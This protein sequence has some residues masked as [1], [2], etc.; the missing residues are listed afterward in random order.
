MIIN[1]FLRPRPQLN[2][3]NKLSLLIN[4]KIFLLPQNRSIVT[5]VK[6]FKKM[7]DPK[8]VKSLQTIPIADTVYGWELSPSICH[9]F[10]SR[11][12]AYYSLSVSP[13]RFTDDFQF[14]IYT[15]TH[16]QLPT[17]DEFVIHLRN[18]YDIERFHK[19][20]FCQ[21]PS[22]IIFEQLPL[23]AASIKNETLLGL[24]DL[25]EYFDLSSHDVCVKKH[26][27]SKRNILSKLTDHSAYELLAGNEHTEFYTVSSSLYYEAKI[28]T[29]NNKVNIMSDYYSNFNH[30]KL[31]IATASE[32]SA[33]FGCKLNSVA[34]YIGVKWS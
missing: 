33:L 13:I 30:G 7:T 5:W 16:L 34:N 22:R 17:L 28:L 10:A 32:F 18:T 29:P 24:D 3:I 25:Y 1:N 20:K 9:F 6:N 31:F 15:N 19:R 4:Q 2:E 26:P 12:Q 8:L 11:H 23:D 27:H 21:P 14:I